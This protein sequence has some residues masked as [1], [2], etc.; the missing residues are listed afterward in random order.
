MKGLGAGVEDARDAVLT[1]LPCSIGCAPARPGR[2]RSGIGTISSRSRWI[3]LSRQPRVTQS[4]ERLTNT[5]PSEPR[6]DTESICRVPALIFRASRAFGL[7]L[8][9]ASQL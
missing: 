9:L 7:F 5:V 6:W 4:K 1:Y 2:P 8:L 3:G